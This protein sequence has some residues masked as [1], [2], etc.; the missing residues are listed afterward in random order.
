[1]THD[2]LAVCYSPTKSNDKLLFA[3]GLLDNTVKI[4]YADS[5]KFFLSL[6]GHKL[7]VTS[8]DISYDCRILISGSA[9]KTIKIWGLDFG[10]CHRSLLGHEDSITLVKFQ[11]DTHYFFSSSKDGCL[12]Y[13]DADRFEQI[14]HLP[15][16]N[17]NS[18]VWSIDISPDSSYVV[19]A[20]QDRSLRV[21]NRGEDL[22][23]IEEEREKFFESKVDNMITQS[24]AETQDSNVLTNDFE[25]LKG[26]EK[27]I[28][29][30]DLVEFE[31]DEI[32][33]L[34]SEYKPNPILLGLDPI[35][36]FLKTLKEIKLP[37]LEG[38][39]LVLPFH[40]V[41][42]FINL[43]L[44]P[45]NKGLEIELCIKCSLFILKC[46]QKRILNTFSLKV[47]IQELNQL[48]KSHISK[49]RSLIGTN[50]SALNYIYKLNEEKHEFKDFI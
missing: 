32:V 47:Q 3:A 38:S 10:D 11:P 5:L 26:A 45:I 39:L 48:I 40:Y 43:I 28:S 30:I 35:K 50:I 4:F 15:G 9:D 1:M 37:D 21:W 6:Y 12:K 17:H 24:S 49:Y 29:S 14:L 8:I 46:H 20:G 41:E 23:F 44:I 27:L 36:Y 42:R 22:V 19:S 33:N 16:H 18:I 2:I 34:E 25:G 31:L 7:P 13:W